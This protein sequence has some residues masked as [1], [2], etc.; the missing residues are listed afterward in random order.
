VHVTGSPQPPPALWINGNR[1]APDTP[2]AL[3]PGSHE[4][5]VRSGQRTSSKRVRLTEGIGSVTIEIGLPGSS[6]QPERRASERAGEARGGSLVPA[7]I[8]LSVG[9]VGL[10]VGAVSGAIAKDKADDLKTRCDGVRC[11]REDAD[12]LDDARSLAT[13]S[14]IGFVVGGVGV[15][16]AGVLFVVRPGGSVSDRSAHPRSPAWVGASGQF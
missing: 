3:D 2:L 4:I 1:V 10:G 9:V 7:W 8:A 6:S 5:V 15:A 16:A 11:L 13:L 14:T 12:Q